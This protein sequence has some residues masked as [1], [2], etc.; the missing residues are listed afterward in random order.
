MAAGSTNV[1]LMVRGFL[2]L[3]IKY[4]LSEEA[5][6]AFVKVVIAV[7]IEFECLQISGS[8]L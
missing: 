7:L 3:A 5:R 2:F 1:F 6:S 8:F 4:E